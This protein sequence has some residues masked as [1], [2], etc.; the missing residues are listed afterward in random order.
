MNDDP[1]ESG[2]QPRCP[3]CDVLMRLDGDGD[4]CP[5]C[6]H[7]EPWEEATHPGHEAP[8]IGYLDY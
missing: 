3:A 8:G 7:R 5:S 1:L 2:A 6:G 4:M